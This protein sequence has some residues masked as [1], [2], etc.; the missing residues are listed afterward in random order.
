MHTKQLPNLVFIGFQTAGK[1]TIGKKVALHLQQPFVDT[2]YLIETTHFPLTCR[3]IYSYYGKDYFREQE[4]K[5]NALIAQKTSQIVA[6]GGGATLDCFDDSTQFIYLKT[7]LSILQ[8]RLEAKPFPPAY[9][10]DQQLE[11]LYLQRTAYYEKWATM[12]LEM[13][14]LTID[15]AVQCLGELHGL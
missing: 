15:Q 2:D 14:D 3:E 13:D 8:K 9:L 11:S 10:K 12:T 1:T 4:N 5:M 7:S 6:V